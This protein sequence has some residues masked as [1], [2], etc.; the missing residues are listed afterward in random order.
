MRLYCKETREDMGHVLRIFYRTSGRH[1]GTIQG[2]QTDLVMEGRRPPNSFV[3]FFCI[4]K[5]EFRSKFLHGLTFLLTESDAQ[6]SAPS[7]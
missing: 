7:L 3:A 6:T 1:K 4:R 2:V 5:R